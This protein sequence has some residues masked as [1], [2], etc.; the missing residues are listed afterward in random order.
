MEKKSRVLK[1]SWLFFEKRRVVFEKRRRGMKKKRFRLIEIEILL[2]TLLRLSG[3]TRR[4]KTGNRMKC[5]FEIGD[6]STYRSELMGW[7]IVWIMMLHFTFTQVKPL[8]FVAQYGFAGVELF[9]MV[10]GLGLFFSLLKDGNLKRFY[11][12]RLLRIFPAYYLLG[13]FGSWL[14]HHDT[15]WQYLVRYSTIGFW[16]GGL[17]AEWYIPSI[18]ALYAVAPL[19]KGLFDRRQ[20]VAV[21]LLCVALL[22][23]SF[24]VVALQ[25]V[26]KGEPHFF[27]LYRI[28]AF[29]LGMAC[30]FWLVNGISAGRK[31][32]LGLMAVGV[33]AFALL[34][35]NHHQVYNYKY[36]S[37]LFL[38]PLLTVVLTT[39]SKLCPWVNPV[40]RAIGTAS[41]E[42]YIIQG[43]FFHA[44]LTGQMTIPAA[45]HD[46]VAVGL[47]VGSTLSGMAAHW[48][49][50]KSGINRLF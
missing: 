10:S 1:K 37:L 39:V 48:L 31:Y 9:I 18:V 2:L 30:A 45:W 33:V 43:M 40:M 23:V 36:F 4:Q 17:Y 5:K 50:G 44:I 6:I 25:L 24:V 32:F 49:I 41:L 21:A 26:D 16:T 35:P 11:K 15:L 22:A 27:L 20:L 13:I 12:K 19:L 38:L 34:Y 29:V 7:A 14:L 3:L 8:G 47:I 46:A 42:I 28:P